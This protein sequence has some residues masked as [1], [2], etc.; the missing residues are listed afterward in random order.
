MPLKIDSV[1]HGRYRILEGLDSGGMG[2][3]YRG[4]DEN[5]GIEVAI[6]ENL[7]V[8][9]ETG[10]QFKREAELLANLRHPNLPRVTDYFVIEG[11][12]QY[13][14]MDF[15][16]G[17]NAHNL[18]MRQ[19]GALSEEEESVL[20]KALQELVHDAEGGTD[21]HKPSVKITPVPDQSTFPA[22]QP[23]DHLCTFIGKV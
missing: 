9:P 17:E 5:L 20:A 18:R 6:K 10:R 15:V 4:R 2:A 11:Q 19:K 8:S 22:E 14:V 3:V 7:F 16:P 12:G 1:L 13:L 23:P 21:N